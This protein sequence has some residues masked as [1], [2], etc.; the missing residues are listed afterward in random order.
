M[1]TTVVD[2]VVVGWWWCS[3]CNG[4]FKEGCDDVSLPLYSEVYMH[5]CDGGGFGGGGLVVVQSLQAT[6]KEGC[7]DMSLPLYSE[8]YTHVHDGG[9]WIGTVLA[10]V[11]SKRVAT[12]CRF[13]CTARSTHMCTTVGGG[14]VQSLQRHVQRGLRRHVASSVQRGLHTCMRRWCVK[15]AKFLLNFVLSTLWRS[16]NSP[17][18]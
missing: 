17:S 1:Y 4:T 11:R 12:T 10:T 2:L 6:F 7:D 9:W 3:P 14:L 15:I 16:G 5:V 18:Q 13:L 8:V